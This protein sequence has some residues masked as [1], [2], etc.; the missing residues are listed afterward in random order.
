MEDETLENIAIKAALSSDIDMVLY[1][2]QLHTTTYSPTT[3]FTTTQLQDIQQ[4]L[5]PLLQVGKL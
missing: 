4:L 5:I 2:D 1:Q 3:L